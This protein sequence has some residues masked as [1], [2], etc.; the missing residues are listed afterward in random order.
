MLVAAI[1]A[2][3]WGWQAWRGGWAPDPARWPT[4]G[5]AVG[6]GNSPV[7][8]PGIAQ[9]GASFAYIDATRGTEPVTP[10]WIAERDAALRAGLRVG[11]VHHFDI[12]APG[13]GQAAAFVR[14]VPREPGALPLAV[15]IDGSGA[16]RE[17]P[18]RAL[19]LSELTTFLT[20]AETH[21]GKPAVIAPSAWAEAEYALASAVN[22]PLWLSSNR[23]EPAPDAGQ[24]TIWQAN[25]ARIVA[26]STGPT[27]WLVANDGTGPTTGG[28]DDAR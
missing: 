13:N 8:W 6:P 4:Q 24:W 27:R 7:S 5:V 19:L 1:G 23:A 3:W 18:T 9:A 14:L 26:G 28:R 15:V 2:L 16:C 10:S 22:R 25:D 21:T 20:Q 17:Q 11:A 12:C